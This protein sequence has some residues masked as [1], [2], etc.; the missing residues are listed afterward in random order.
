MSNRGCKHSDSRWATTVGLNSAD[1][2]CATW[3]AQS[4]QDRSAPRP[5]IAHDR[6]RHNRYVETPALPAP[7]P[8][9]LLFVHTA[10]ARLYPFTAA[11]SDAEVIPAQVSARRLRTAAGP[12]PIQRP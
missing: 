10:G 9:D 2:R 7:R 4:Y 8:A 12:A 1:M 3:P 6:R 11:M 5:V